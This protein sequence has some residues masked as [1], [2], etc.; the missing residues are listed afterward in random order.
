MESE[1]KSTNEIETN[2]LIL[3]KSINW[4]NNIQKNNLKVKYSSISLLKRIFKII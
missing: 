1:D 4:V 3:L 2:I